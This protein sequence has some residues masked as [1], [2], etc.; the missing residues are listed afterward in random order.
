M[1]KLSILIV[2]DN[3]RF[4]YSLR[5]YL[6]TLNVDVILATD[7]MLA[8]DMIKR[9]K[10]NIVLLDLNLPKLNGINVLKQINNIDN[11]QIKVI[12]ISGERILINK[13]P[14]ESYEFIKGVFYKPVSLS[15]IHHSIEQILTEKVNNKDITKLKKLLEKFDFNKNSKGYNY[16]VECMIEFLNS[17][18]KS[19]N[20]E[21]TIYSLIAKRHKVKDTN[22][23]KWCISKALKSMVRFTDKKILSEYFLYCAN[24]TPKYFMRTV[25]DIIKDESY[26]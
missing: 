1:E 13:I 25:Y 9:Y 21:K 12:I 3:K 24:I 7:G 5:S 4:I 18:N 26:K 11:S 20:L 15:K 6:K 14:T 23:I 16:L 17:P 10:P 8:L 19:I 2:E 22:Q